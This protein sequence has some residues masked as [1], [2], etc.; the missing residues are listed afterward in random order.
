MK[1]IKKE[2]VENDLPEESPLY[3]INY[4]MDKLY[5]DKTKESDDDVVEGLMYYELLAALTLAQKCLMKHVKK[6][7]KNK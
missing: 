1:D 7:I 4:C 2:D 3:G 5:K 6:S